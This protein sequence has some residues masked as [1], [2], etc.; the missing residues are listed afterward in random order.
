MKRTFVTDFDGTVTNEDAGA[1]LLR[2]HGHDSWVFWDWCVRIGCLSL[3]A[4]Q[5]LQWR[6]VSADRDVLAESARNSMFLRSGFRGFVDRVRAAGDD[7]LIV[8][9]GFRFY[10]EAILGDLA[11]VLPIVANDLHDSDGGKRIAWVDRRYWCAV[12]RPCKAVVA[13]RLLN[14]S[15]VALGDGLSDL[16]LLRS[17]VPLYAVRG[18]LLEKRGRRIGREGLSSFDTFDTVSRAEWAY[19]NP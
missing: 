17:S 15:V 1:A 9:S 3:P 14:H 10:I 4:A 16:C 8:S 5:E 18:S 12:H 2:S 6:G 7:L 11:K 19:V 13:Q